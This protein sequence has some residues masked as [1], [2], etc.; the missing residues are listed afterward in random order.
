MELSIVYRMTW[1]LMVH[2]IVHF[3][4]LSTNVEVMT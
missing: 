3:V 4:H 2:Y 1:I